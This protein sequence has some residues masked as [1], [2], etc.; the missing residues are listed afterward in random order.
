MSIRSSS[1]RPLR[2][3]M[4]SSRVFALLLAAAVV[5]PVRLAGQNGNT[6]ALAPIPVTD[7]SCRFGATNA[8]GKPKKNGANAVTLVGN[9]PPRTFTVEFDAANHVT[10]FHSVVNWPNP[11]P[12]SESVDVFY[13]PT[14][15]I[16]R[17]SRTM[18]AGG[19]KQPTITPLLGDDN[20]VV[21][22]MVRQVLAKCK[23]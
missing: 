4:R 13:S 15:A 20:E 19:A 9:F 23:S 2:G 12:G 14:G 6:R 8:K 5:Q 22:Q 10:A 16:R 17:G 11:S 18:R 21:A 7:V 3:S 1:V